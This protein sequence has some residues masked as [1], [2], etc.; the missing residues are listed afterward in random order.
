MS[1][2]QIAPELLA[3]LRDAEMQLLAAKRA[4]IVAD[5]VVQFARAHIERLYALQPE[6]VVEESGAITRATKPEAPAA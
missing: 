5:G 4:A 2:E 3:L 1:Q 6:D